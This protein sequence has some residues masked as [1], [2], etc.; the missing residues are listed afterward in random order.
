MSTA[1]EWEKWGEQ[2]PYYGVISS[3]VHRD[4]GE[5]EAF[6]E[7]GERYFKGLV[8]RFADIGIPLERHGTALDYGCGVG[9]VLTPMSRYFASTLGIDVS[10]AMLDEARR[11]VGAGAE[12]CRLVE[13]DLQ[14]CLPQH[15]FDF[16]HSTLVFQHIPTA[17]GLS[18]LSALMERLKPGG[19][20]AL[21]LPISARRPLRH[22]LS[23]LQKRNALVCKLTRLAILRPRPF[24]PVMQMNLYPVAKL[25]DTWRQHGLQ[26]RFL[27]LN[28]DG[29]VWQGHWCLV[30]E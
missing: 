29:D 16:I 2:D 20:I 15:R 6:L 1:R 3:P 13:G 21:C 27:D 23:S 26:V 14:A 8:Q 24:E 19:R 5:R 25:F 28:A 11:N 7:S 12:L 22:L 4:G 10:Q 30:K 18:I 17:Q 9:R